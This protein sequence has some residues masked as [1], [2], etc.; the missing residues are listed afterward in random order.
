MRK[1]D[2]DWKGW[3]ICISCGAYRP[4]EE[5]QVG[6]YYKRQHDYTTLLLT[7]WRNVN[8]QCVPCNGIKRG[9]PIGYAMGLQ[10]KYGKK[11]LFELEK[12]YKTPRYWKYTELEKIIEAFNENKH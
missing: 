8:L 6:H 2:S 10:R 3:A 7:E 9:N 4:V 5:L 1:R 11:I 12:D